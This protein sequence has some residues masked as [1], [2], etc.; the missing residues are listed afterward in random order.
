M[1]RRASHDRIRGVEPRG[2]RSDHPAWRIWTACTIVTAILILSNA[3]TPLYIHWQSELQFSSSTLTA[4]FSSYVVGLL[5]ALVLAGQLSDR[6]GT[7]MVLLPGLGA[8]MLACLLFASA[9]SVVSLV[10]ARFASG[11]GVGAAITAGVAYVIELGSARRSRQA[12]LLGSTAVALGAA[13]GPLMAGSFASFVERPTSAIFFTELLLLLIAAC[14]VIVLPSRPPAVDFRLAEL[15][16]PGAPRANRMHLTAGVASFGSAL[17]AT[18]FVLALGP[19]VLTELTG[20]DSPLVA[21]SMACVMFAAGAIVQPAAMSL[22]L[23]SVFILSAVMLLIAM[24]GIAI[25]VRARAP[26]P[27]LMTAAFAGCAYGLAQLGGLTLIARHVPT[28]RRGEANAVLNIGG[29]VPCGLMP[30]LTGLLVDRAGLVFAANC[31]AAVVAAAGISACLFI[32]GSLKR[33]E[34]PPHASSSSPKCFAHT[35]CIHRYTGDD[36]SPRRPADGLTPSP[37]TGEP[38]CQLFVQYRS[39]GPAP[40]SSS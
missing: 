39:A 17:S 11:V 35:G 33:I 21:G 6:L 40:R 22:S 18:A 36:S 29:Y 7:R 28:Q 14:F 10:L 13:L 31:F 16:F 3:P 30:I 4:L 32:V 2:S 1:K 20:A 27:L 26:G 38:P 15:H 5:A 19:S 23:R 12:P 24:A 34:A 9:H 37:T 25:A 8:G